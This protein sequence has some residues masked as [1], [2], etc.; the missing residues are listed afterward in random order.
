MQTFLFAILRMV[1]GQIFTRE[2]MG[3]VVEHVEFYMNNTEMSNEE[4]AAI[5][6]ENAI[7]KAK[8]IGVNLGKSGANLLLETAVSLV[9]TKMG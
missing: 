6:K 4:K 5:V 7:A 9:K 1:I 3:Y 2:L 8:E